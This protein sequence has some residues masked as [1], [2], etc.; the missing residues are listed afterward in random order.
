MLS[1]LTIKK[2]LYIFDQGLSFLT[3]INPA[4]AITI[5]TLNIKKVLLETISSNKFLLIV[6]IVLYS[7][8]IYFQNENTLTKKSIFSLSV[9]ISIFLIIDKIDLYKI[10]T[11]RSINHQ[12]LFLILFFLIIDQLF[13]FNLKEY[14]TGAVRGS[15]LFNERSHLAIY[16]LPLIFFSLLRYNSFLP[17]GLLAFSLLF[18][19]SLTL[20]VGLVLFFG[21]IFLKS[22][23]LYPVKSLKYLFV[24]ILIT[25][26]AIT[27]FDFLY[28]RVQGV[29][30]FID[31]LEDVPNITSKELEI[32]LSGLVWI[33]G[34]VMAYDN[35]LYSNF[36]GLGF[37]N[38]GLN[39]NA[40]LSFPSHFGYNYDI[41]N[42]ED[43][44]F[45]ASKIVS[46][47]GVIGIL[48]VLFLSY[49]CFSN[50]IRFCS[51]ADDHSSLSITITLKF[52]SS[53]LMFSYLYIRGIGY[54]QLSFLL[55]LHLLFLDFNSI[56]KSHEK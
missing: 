34:W 49:V 50:I 48:I 32:Y 36:L 51:S 6:L 2:Y 33:N 40:G 55:Y 38:M 25:I 20:I 53:I 42:A 46:E 47:F 3:G 11:E 31:N 15:G 24:I 8:I 43:G 4:S 37:N 30:I 27:Q 18:F 22:L 17:Y 35:L 44:S 5:V 7:I 28:A 56:V 39:P 13:T 16:S 41:L 10:I 29:L 45:L 21:I 54:F 9:M 52:I 12:L 1:F 14:F 23:I 19:N 26:L